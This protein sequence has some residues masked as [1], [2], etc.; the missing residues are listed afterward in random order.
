[1]AWSGEPTSKAHIRAT[2]VANSVG[3]LE[4]IFSDDKPLETYLPTVLPSQLLEAIQAEAVSFFAGAGVSVPSGIGGWTDHYVPLLR[5]LGAGALLG[6]AYPLPEILQLLCTSPQDESRIFDG[7]RDSFRMSGKKAN[8]YHY[9]MLKSRARTI[10][11]TNYDLLFEQAVLGHSF[12]HIVV[13]NDAELLNNFSA[14]SLII[15][16]NGDFE[17]AKFAPDLE[18]DMVFIEEQFDTAEVRRREIW[19]LF[20][21][22]YRN[23]L[24]VFVG[25]SF[26]DPALRRILSVAAKAIP[27]SR[28]QHL[29]LMKVPEN[30]LDR[31]IHR[32]YAEALKRRNI[33]TL[34]FDDFAAIEKFVCRIGAQAIRPIVGFSGTA[35]IDPAAPLTGPTGV[36][37][38]PKSVEEWCTIAGRA[39]AAH[40]SRVTSGHGEGVGVPAVTAAFEQNPTSARFYLRKRGTTKFS[41]LAPAIVVRGDA[42]EDMRERFVSELDLLIAL[43]GQKTREATSGTVAEIKLALGNQ[44]PVL[45]FPQAGGDAAGF[46][47]ELVSQARNAFVDAS[48]ADALSKANAKIAAVPVEDLPGFME[49][50]LPILAAE[51]IAQMMGAAIKRARDFIDRGPGS[52]W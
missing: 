38:D 6:G 18:W 30:P 10:W 13:K 22:H 27:R 8:V 29:L 40:N 34:F 33:E 42:L 12:E 2:A 32:L 46:A 5:K 26:R 36:A 14:K 17:G 49:S 52:D 45:I 39:L 21:D 48:M 43:G 1:M 24:I 47:P 44:V 9:A 41:R 35:T 51:L 3:D 28:Y 4:A 7:F 20:E 37:I 11:T 16:L 31:T 23:K 15:K 50:D 25:V 19:R